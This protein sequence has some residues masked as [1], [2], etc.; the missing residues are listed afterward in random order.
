MP[1]DITIA[2]KTIRKGLN[3]PKLYVLSII[4]NTT[5]SE[6]DMVEMAENIA[7]NI[8]HTDYTYNLQYADHLKIHESNRRIKINA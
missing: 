1:S 4:I 2:P 8:P 5:M 6:S 7:N 3:T